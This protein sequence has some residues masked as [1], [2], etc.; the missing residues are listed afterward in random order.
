M[1]SLAVLIFGA[2]MCSAQIPVAR[3][4]PGFTLPDLKYK[5]HDLADYRGKVT[6]VEFMRTDCP[7]CQAL[8]PTLEQVKSKYGD[9][10]VVLSIVNPPD[11]PAA[12]GRFIQ[13][14]KATSTFLLDC[15]QMTASY[16]RATPQNPSVHLPRVM[17]IDKNGMIRGDIEETTPGGFSLKNITAAVEPLLK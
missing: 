11:T 8:A 10:V 7:Q 2:I 3:R 4:A 17:V 13:T 14:H 15:G 1:K 12:I 6:I 9:Q 16:M 5:Y